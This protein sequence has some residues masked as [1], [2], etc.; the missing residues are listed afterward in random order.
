VDDQYQPGI[1]LPRLRF[2]GQIRSAWQRVFGAWRPDRRTV[3]VLLVAMFAGAVVDRLLTVDGSWSFFTGSLGGGPPGALFP[4]SMQQ[5]L[6][7]TTNLLFVPV[8]VLVLVGA[9]GLVLR[10]SWGLWVAAGALAAV[11]ALDLVGAATYLTEV[12]G[13]L[14]LRQGVGRVVSAFGSALP[15][16]VLL[17]S[18]APAEDA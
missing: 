9:V 14:G 3:G 7:A 5:V 17:W 4:I 18:R 1:P 13:A 12:H 6:G 2:G 11:L 8:D 15:L 16:A 10:R